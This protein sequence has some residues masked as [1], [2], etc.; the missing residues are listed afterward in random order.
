MAE[1]VNAIIQASNYAISII[2]VGVGQADFSKMDIL[3][4]FIFNFLKTNY[5]F[6]FFFLLKYLRMRE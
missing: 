5:L 2:I 3:V 6:T 1:T 4:I